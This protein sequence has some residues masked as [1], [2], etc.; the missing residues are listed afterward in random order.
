MSYQEDALRTL[1]PLEPSQ[2]FP[3]SLSVFEKALSAGLQAKV[4]KARLFYR[5]DDP[6]YAKRILK[7]AQA[8]IGDSEK[9]GRKIYGVIFR[10]MQD[11][12]VQVG[13]LHALFGLLDEVGELVLEFLTALV[14]ERD[15]DVSAVK[16]ELG[17]IEWYTALMR[18]TAGLTQEEVQKANLEKLEVRYEETPKNST[19]FTKERNRE[20]EQ[21]AME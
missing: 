21:R 14:Q 16:E 20:A 11:V 13:H 6:D 17:D 19:D 4:L 9:L 12:P 15:L 1:S 2:K 5:Q 8:E 18:E 10:E 3:L 7:E